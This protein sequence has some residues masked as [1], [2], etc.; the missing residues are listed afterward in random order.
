MTSKSIHTLL[1]TLVDYAGLFPPA[2]LSMQAAVANYADYRRSPH[3]WVLGRFIVP[4]SR[5]DEMAAAMKAIGAPDDGHAWRI[6]V[7][8]GESINDDVATAGIFNGGSS[9]A[10]IDALEVK[11]ASVDAIR[12]IAR[13]APREM[14]TYVEIPVAEDPRALV[15]AIAAV[16]LR[17]K[18]RTG[19]VTPEAI[20]IVEQVG[21]FMRACYAAGVGFKAT[22]GLH[23]ALRAE[24]ALTYAP[25]APRGVMHG[26]LNVFLA[27]AF[28]YNGLTIRDAHA[29]LAAGTLDG[30]EINDDRLAWREYV[31]TLAELSTIRRRFAI[32][33]GSC[34]FTEPVEDLVQME[35]LS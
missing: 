19:G 15:D 35:L 34:S 2:G 4:V 29:L 21:A 7:L 5:L 16:K 1:H 23:H 22:A 27:A 32:A 6:S 30:V 31:V 13:V 28:Q 8:A 17:A 33:F 20:P 3:A 9:N 26:F 18:I 12:A 10:L 14:K 25:D 24:R 11:A